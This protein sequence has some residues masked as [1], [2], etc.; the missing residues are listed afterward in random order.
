MLLPVRPFLEDGVFGS[1]RLLVLLVPPYHLS[2]CLG[3]CCCCCCGYGCLYPD[4]DTVVVAAPVVVFGSAPHTALSIPSF[5]PVM[6]GLELEDVDGEF[7]DPNRH[8]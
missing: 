6:I 7:V 8:R 1:Y 2:L 5:V 4:L 3:T